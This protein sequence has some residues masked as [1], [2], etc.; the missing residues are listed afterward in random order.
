MAAAADKRAELD[1]QI[2]LLTE[3]GLQIRLFSDVARKMGVTT[4][5]E[6]E[7]RRR[8]SAMSLLILF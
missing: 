5:V 2:S 1:L 8:S 7:L 4:Q 6:G 3:H